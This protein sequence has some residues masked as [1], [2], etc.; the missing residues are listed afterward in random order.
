MILFIRC[1]CGLR[2]ESW[3]KKNPSIFTE[4]G[5]YAFLCSN[6]KAVQYFTDKLQLPVK[7]STVRKFKLAWMAKNNVEQ[8]N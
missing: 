2:F 8:V 7:E 3:Y 5:H 6:S 1:T 4:I